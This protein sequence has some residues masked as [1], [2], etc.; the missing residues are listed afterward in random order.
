MTFSVHTAKSGSTASLEPDRINYS[1]GASRI[2][3]GRSLD[4]VSELI[5]APWLSDQTDG[6]LGDKPTRTVSF[7]R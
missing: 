3:R 6:D 4:K 5:V 7:A 2:C 1:T